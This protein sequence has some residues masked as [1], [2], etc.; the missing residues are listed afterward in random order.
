MDVLK[1]IALPASTEHF[2][3]LLLILNLIYVV[4]LPY[5]GFLLG[6]S[7]LSVW[8]DRKGRT[9]GTT[10]HVRLAKEL[11]DVAM[12][13]K[14]VVTF[15]GIIPGLALV[16]VYAQLLQQTQAISVSLM[17]YGF[18]FLLA[19]SILLYTYK[20]T[21][22]LE[23]VYVR[24]AEALRREGNA[25]GPAGEIAVYRE[26][27]TRTHVRAGNN[28][29]ILLLIASFLCIGA[30][31][32]T[33]DANEWAQ[34]ENVFDVFAS[35]AILM[36]F[37]QFLAISF[38]ATGIGILF[39]F[40]CR[41]EETPDA[42]GEY[43]RLVRRVGLRTAIISLLLQPVFLVLTILLLPQGVLSGSL[44]GLAGMSLGLF[45]LAAHF[46]YAFSRESR[47]G[48]AAYAFYTVGCALLLLFTADQ[49]AVSNA[50]KEEA[51]KVAMVYDR[52][53]EELRTRLGVVMVSLS[54]EDIYNAKCSACHLFDQKK[55]GPPYNTVIPKYA[56]K[57]DQLVAF[58]LNPA[59]VDP[60]YPN[61]PN[62]GLKP[63]EADSIATFLLKK[64]AGASIQATTP[65]GKAMQ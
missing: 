31:G 60:A 48:Y 54:G 4:F 7:L 16:F 30:V 38:G 1:S 46:V 44:Y 62:Q 10:I 9:T 40:F 49:I 59:K 47:P 41:Q 43:A 61:M 23:S 21:F 52:E 37:F 65:G 5:L 3:L 11:M 17:G 15:L 64:L 19:A 39:F 24:V 63:G 56:G 32:V 20:F 57:K 42:A 27:N 25:G 29:A 22:R 53:T 35:P 12:Y 36:R 34:T 51:V 50:T 26:T 13:N 55:I 8:Y 33:I 18:L 14:S 6:T 2:R 28:G 45:F 58:I